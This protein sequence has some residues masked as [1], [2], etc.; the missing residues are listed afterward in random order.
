MMVVVLSGEI[1]NFREIISEWAVEKP[2]VKRV[3]IFGSRV[4]GNHREDSDL[5]VA[6]EINSAAIRGEDYSGGFATYAF[7]SKSWCN[8]LN[9]L[10]GLD[11]DL[12]FYKEGETKTIQIAL[13]F[14]SVVVYEKLFD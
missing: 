2:L 7:E 4:R 14:S 6:I 8:E 10:I 5:D 9:D 13:D 3:W 11:V 1:L 12:Q